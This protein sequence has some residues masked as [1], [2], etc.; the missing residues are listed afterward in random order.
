MRTL[1]LAI[2]AFA[3][4]AFLVGLKQPDTMTFLLAAAAAASAATA[5]LSR[6]LFR[7]S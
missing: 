1:S 5:F 3:F 2:A 4:A 6:R 7:R